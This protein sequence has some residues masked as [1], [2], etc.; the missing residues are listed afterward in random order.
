MKR[1]GFTLIELLVVIAIIA[2]LAAILFPVFSQAKAAAKKS[3]CLSNMKQ[4]NLGMELYLG[5]FD[6]MH[7]TGKTC[8][9]PGQT[10]D[11][12]W[13][14]HYWPFLL[15]AYLQKKNPENLL[16]QPGDIYTCPTTRIKQILNGTSNFSGGGCP[17]GELARQTAEWGLVA[18]NGRYPF[19]LNYAINEHIPDEWPSMSVWEDPADSYRF[20]EGTDPDIEGDELDELLT[21]GAGDMPE[22]TA[23]NDDRR[24]SPSHGNGANVSY[25]DGHV[26]F[27]RYSY[28]VNGPDAQDWIWT[29]PMS[30]NGGRPTGIP[31][32]DCGPWTAPADR[33]S[34]SGACV[35]Q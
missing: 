21:V 13:G 32:D 31:L 34:A 28:R 11:G 1:S 23:P 18:V 14:H 29:V 25:V 10:N 6:D 30:G 27:L 33:R 16:G 17:P 22:V 12:S 9:L 35:S 24:R 2:I 3:V 19:W 5:D 8:G 7:P 26:K 20:M 15:K 4:L